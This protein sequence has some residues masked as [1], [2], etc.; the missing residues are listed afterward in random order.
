[1]ECLHRKGAPQ[2]H[3]MRNLNADDQRMR[4]TLVRRI[5]VVTTA[6][7]ISIYLL[8]MIQSIL[9]DWLTR[10]VWFPWA[11]SVVRLLGISE[12]RGYA[13]LF[14]PLA[15]FFISLALTVL[16]F[17]IFRIKSWRIAAAAA[18]VAVVWRHYL[19]DYFDSSLFW[20]AEDIAIFGAVLLAARIIEHL[21]PK[22]MSFENR[23]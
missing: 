16:V 10:H 11:N 22:K 17:G 12:G 2:V 4:I 15:I 14:A 3:V 18:G 7:L 8:V 21:P 9:L 13:Y 19:F 6:M 5:A 20:I 1:M 23:K